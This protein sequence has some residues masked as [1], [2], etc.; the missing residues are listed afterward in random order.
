MIL[1]GFNRQV[2]MILL[3]LEK[4]DEAFQYFVE[5]KYSN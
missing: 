4:L 2:V 3:Q 1:G 5:K